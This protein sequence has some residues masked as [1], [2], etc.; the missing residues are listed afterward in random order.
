MHNALAIILPS[1]IADVNDGFVWKFR[2][3]FRPAMED[4][5]PLECIYGICARV[6]EYR[7]M[8]VFQNTSEQLRAAI[9]GLWQRNRALPAGEDGTARAK[10]VALIAVD[11]NDRLAAVSSVYRAPFAHSGLR[12]TENGDFYFFRTFVQ[13]GDRTHNLPKKLTIHTYEHLKAVAAPDKPKGMIIVAENPKLTKKMLEHGLGP[14]GWVHIGQD[15][16]GKQV[17]RH[18]F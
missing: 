13:P 16:R 1:G 3:F 8:P 11:G 14:F 10:Q 12:L 18:D 15:A 2:K 5:T 4:I 17:F 6:G 9:I 7:I